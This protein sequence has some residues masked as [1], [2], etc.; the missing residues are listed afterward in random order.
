MIFIP[1]RQSY[2]SVMAL[3][4]HAK[5]CCLKVSRCPRFCTKYDQFYYEITR[6]KVKTILARYYLCADGFKLIRKD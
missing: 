3:R 2:T 4:D 1:L 5:N 6:P